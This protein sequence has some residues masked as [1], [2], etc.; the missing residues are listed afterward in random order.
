MSILS[1]VSQKIITKY[2][3]SKI[4]NAGKKIHR[5]RAKK[6]AEA[7]RVAKARKARVS[8]KK[9]KKSQRKKKSQKR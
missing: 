7:N 8:Q 6:K 5:E 4:S 2:N 9:T 1:T 3:N